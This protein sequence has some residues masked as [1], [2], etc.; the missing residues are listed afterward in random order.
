MSVFYDIV[1]DIKDILQ[2][3]ELLSSIKFVDAMKTTPMPNPIK[4]IHA[5]IDIFKVQVV[6]G[7]FSGYMG[8]KNA[9][10]LYGQLADVDVSI[11]IYSPFSIGSQA[12]YD[13]FSDIC[14]VLMS[15]DCQNL[16][17]QSVSSENVTYVSNM[18][19]FILNCTVKISTFIGTKQSQSN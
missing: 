11:K 3:S 16:N 18:S 8:K 14:K 10:E 19:N 13:T 12:C 6:N 5:A 1:S 4:K 2:N 9:E 15:S 7:I 17:I